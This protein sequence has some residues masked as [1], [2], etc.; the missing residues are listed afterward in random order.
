LG[1]GELMNQLLR[2]LV[3]AISGVPAPSAEGAAAAGGRPGG[4]DPRAALA[5]SIAAGLPIVG[6]TL[7]GMGDAP[8]DQDALAEL[9]VLAGQT[10]PAT[11][12][13]PSLPIAGADVLGF[14]RLTPG[15]GS[16]TPDWARG[17]ATV[18][19]VPFGQPPGPAAW[20][21]GILPVTPIEVTRGTNGPAI[22]YLIVASATPA[23][24]GGVT[25]VRFTSGS[26][27]LV[28]PLLDS[29]IPVDGLV[30]VAFTSATL[31]F[32]GPLPSQATAIAIPAGETALFTVSPEPS[33]ASSGGNLDDDGARATVSLP[34]SVAFDFAPTAT[35]VARL[36]DAALTVYGASFTL[37]GGAAGSSFD[38][39][40]GEW[41]TDFAGV[42]G[43]VLSLDGARSG[44]FV[45]SGSARASAGSYRLPVA[46]T[47]PGRLAAAEGGGSLGLSLGD[48]VS[49][50]WG[51]IP[52]PVPL[53]GTLLEVRTGQL[54]VSATTAVRP[55]ADR[56]A[57]WDAGIRAASLVL[58]G[59]R[60]TLVISEQSAQVDIVR[61]SG[62]AI[63]AHLDQPCLADGAMPDF[64][65]LT[66]AYLSGQA[67]AGEILLI[68]A[69]ASPPPAVTPPV[70]SY[71]IQNAL[72]RTA[73]IAVLTVHGA[74]SGGRAASGAL[75]FTTALEHVTPTL[76]DPYVSALTAAAQPGATL[77]A[78][79]AWA[80]PATS[81]LSFEIQRPA[82]APATAAA[83]RGDVLARGQDLLLDVSSSGDQFGVSF[84]A[85]ALNAAQVSG[86]TLQLSGEQSQLYAL[87]QVSWEAVITD[88]PRG[89]YAAAGA[90]AVDD[91]P[92][93]TVN[94]PTQ[95]LR[96]MTPPGFIAQFLADYA[97]G[98]DLNAHFTL[99]FGLEATVSTAPARRRSI[100]LRPD[101]R[102]E[103]PAFAGQRGGLQLS[104]QAKTSTKQRLPVLPGV[105]FTT[106]DPADADYPA[107]MLNH[108]SAAADNT[109]EFWDQQFLTGLQDLGP[110]VPLERID[111]SGYGASTFSDF[112]DPDIKVGVTEARFDVIV[113]RT[114]Y[115]LV[116]VQSFILHH[117]IP[118]VNTTI[119]ERGG[120]GWI[121]RH[122]TGWRAK[123]PGLFQYET[124]TT[125]ETGGVIGLYNVRNIQALDQPAVPAG[126]KSYAPVL[127]DADVRL[128]TDPAEHG[129][130]IRGGAIGVAG[131][132][133]ADMVAGTRFAGWVDMTASTSGPTLADAVALM[134]AVGTADGSLTADVEVAATKIA[135]TLSGLDIAAT[136][137][138][139]ARTLGVALRGL[140]HLPRDGSWSVA[141]RASSQAAPSPVDPLTPVPLVRNHAD[142]QT[143]HLADPGDVLN[144][145]APVISYGIL[146]STGTQKVFFEQPT[147]TDGAGQ[148][149]LGFQQ[150]PKLADVGALLG[151][152]DV[153][154]DVSSLLSFV[155][156]AGFS[157]A[158]DGF[159]IGDGSGPSQPLTRS[160]T[161]PD[162]TLIPLGPISV[163]MATNQ[164]P[165]LLPPSHSPPPAPPLQSVVTVTID[166]LAVSPAPRWSV[167]ITNVA[168][169]LLVDGMSSSDDPLVAVVGDIVAAERKAPTLINLAF[170]YGSSLS[171]V[172][173]VL[174]GIE[175]LAQAL[176]GGGDTGLDVR[177]AGT[178]LS[179]RDAVSLP[180]LPLGFGYI[181]GISLDLG[182]DLDVLAQSMSFQVGVGTDQDP[183]SWLASPLAGNGLLQLGA[184]RQLG[185]RMQGGIGVG[186][187]IDVAI[188]SGSASVC[189]AVQLDT[190]KTPFGVMV[191]LTGNASVDVL[192]GLASASLSLTAGLGVQVSPGPASDLTHIPP[193]LD[194]FIRQ[195][196]ITL[197]AQVAVAI[198]LTVGWLIHVDWSGSWGF[199]ETVSG[200]ALTSVLP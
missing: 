21:A 178:R 174:S 24:A 82:A 8:G 85:E 14:L 66:A 84:P 41:A 102:L 57:L 30:G 154:P 146:Q 9:A 101:L 187:G 104:L 126:G 128:V 17:I 139:G 184:S 141:K 86:Q 77:L 93:A 155:G 170:G 7:L 111:L 147:I 88:D 46:R 70:E 47:I 116:E 117:M 198:H 72:L 173:Q 143:W 25:T 191:L 151:I 98:A 19:A 23:S 123:A 150:Q 137:G 87:P 35:K 152:S 74:I 181:E 97:R 135:F 138:P 73:G 185:V 40:A 105:S 108:S 55:F 106:T 168:F 189:L 144:L 114:C 27:W 29:L 60:G 71:V 162:K 100:A 129:L 171:I 65:L 136:P 165:G 112:N 131:T 121:E 160:A 92:A 81:V 140:P 36:D 107:A 110:F 91:G 158:G 6:D 69:T 16:G 197:S 76:P 59:P 166:P 83:S 4:F 61:V 34:A 99:P 109:A 199:S 196:S 3:R 167:T 169:K 172:Q 52:G 134:D 183:F 75:A 22:A 127:F 190:T 156:F 124:G 103:R 12:A 62:A 10:G 94:V 192:D 163:V 113:G 200:S 145:S 89:I 182:F 15:P 153:L 118:V 33:T 43:P 32:S 79:V 122:T 1:V 67:G 193:K 186:L 188:A 64:G 95:A 161:L 63:E 51:N 142:T 48:G 18:G 26:A 176:P 177:F 58:H 39:Q 54:Q 42:E 53:T 11:P 149:P 56:Y 5:R 28:G 119:F 96:P 133:G 125:V 164:Q 115:T 194:D 20:A 13:E 195:T 44:A 120:A 37:S 157:A 78:D 2:R 130:V 148:G 132:A 45:T 159:A 50:R 38:S 180:Q 80:T 175:A 31:E 179:V 68:H 49:A 90:F